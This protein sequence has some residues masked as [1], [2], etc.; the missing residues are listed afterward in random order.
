MPIK[1]L[2]TKNNFVEGSKKLCDI[3]ADSKNEII[4]NADV[5]GLGKIELLAAGSTCVTADL[6]VG[7]LKSDGTW[8]WA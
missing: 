7:L 6:D 5:Q 1:V 2:E 3:Y 4:P 8:S